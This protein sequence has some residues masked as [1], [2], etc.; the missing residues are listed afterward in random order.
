VR[1]FDRYFLLE[2][3]EVARQSGVLVDVGSYVVE[4]DEVAGKLG[5]K[6]FIGHTTHCSNYSLISELYY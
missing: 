6:L 5:Y 3:G 2:K 1:Y 4:V